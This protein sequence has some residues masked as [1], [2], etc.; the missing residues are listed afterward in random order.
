MFNS[1]LDLAS[2]AAN[3][4]S[5]GLWDFG[6]A[7]ARERTSSNRAIEIGRSF[8][9]LRMLSCR[10]DEAGRNLHMNSGVRRP[11]E[12]V[13]ETIDFFCPACNSRAPSPRRLFFIAQLA[14][15]DSAY[16]I[17]ELQQQLCSIDP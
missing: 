8:W 17:G 11:D 3:S 4:G 14:Q 16:R 6:P 9:P 5:C 7:A 13:S 15:V 1:K 12:K 2:S 10:G